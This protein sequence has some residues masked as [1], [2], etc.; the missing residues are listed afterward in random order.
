MG[1][2]ARSYLKACD[3]PERPPLAP[4][5]TKIVVPLESRIMKKNRNEIVSVAF[6][7]KDN[8]GISVETV[9]NLKDV[10]P[11]AGVVALAEGGELSESERE[12]INA[13]QMR[14]AA[15]PR[16]RKDAFDGVTIRRWSL[17]EEVA[18]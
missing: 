4:K 13:A 11:P 6:G 10:Q 3:L 5:T 12:A 16:I 8:F 9:F 15:L 7:S 2:P 17:V 14:H 1:K 18:R